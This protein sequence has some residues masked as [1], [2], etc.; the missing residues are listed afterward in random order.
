MNEA[1]SQKLL[2]DVAEIKAALREHLAVHRVLAN[3]HRA[4]Y[5]TLAGLLGSAVGLLAAHWK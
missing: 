2:D 5:G 1:Q 4:A 3:L